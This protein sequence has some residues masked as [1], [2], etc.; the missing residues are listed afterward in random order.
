MTATRARF[1]RRVEPINLDH[2]S[3]VPGRFVLQLP[4][5]LAPAHV[6]NRFCEGRVLHHVLD[7]KAL[8]HDRLV[9]TNQFRRKLMLRVFSSIRSSRVDLATRRRCFSRFFEPFCLW[10]SR[11]CARASFFSSRAA[12]LGFSKVWPSEVATM[13]LSPRSMPICLSF[14]ASATISSSTRI[15]IK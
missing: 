9:L 11:R 12:Y 3:P 1:T 10:E 2:A 6:G 14:F 13:V 7:S 8:D 5:E 4:H 15:E